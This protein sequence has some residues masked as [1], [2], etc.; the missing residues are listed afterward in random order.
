MPD[1][2][3]MCMESLEEGVSTVHTIRIPESLWTR[4]TEWAARSG[5]G[6]SDALRRLL[7]LGLEQEPGVVVRPPMAWMRASGLDSQ[8]WV[9]ASVPRGRDWWDLDSLVGQVP[10]ATRY[11]KRSGRNASMTWWQVPKQQEQSL[12]VLFAGRADRIRLH[13]IGNAR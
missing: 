13:E 11:V 12:R 7:A 9:F 6:D 1:C 4:V 8:A 10:G 2:M 3:L 5:V